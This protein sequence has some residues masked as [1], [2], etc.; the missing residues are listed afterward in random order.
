M[1]SRRGKI[2]V[3]K[4]EGPSEPPELSTT[5][6]I[7]TI[8]RSTALTIVKSTLL[9]TEYSQARCPKDQGPLSRSKKA[10]AC[11][12]MMKGKAHKT[13]GLSHLTR[14]RRAVDPS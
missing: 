11:L 5:E 3:S 8:I 7:E 13:N 9:L 10:P 2:K 1:D 12:I 4:L 6:W 14:P